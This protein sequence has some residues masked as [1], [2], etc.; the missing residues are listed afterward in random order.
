MPEFCM[1]TG[2][3]EELWNSASK[4]NMIRDIINYTKPEVQR[5]IVDIKRE[6]FDRI[7]MSAES[8]IRFSSI[9]YIIEGVKL[10]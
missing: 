5:R 7:K 4:F 6:F 8:E 9:P 1:V 3:T 2:L 10:D